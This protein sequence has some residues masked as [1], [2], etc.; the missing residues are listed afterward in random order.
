MARTPRRPAS[1]PPQTPAGASER[2]RIVEAFMALLG[3][4]P[5]EEVGFGD[6]AARAD[7][8]LADLRTL[9]GS[10][11][12]ILAFYL[13]EIDRRVLAGIDADM[14]EEPPRERLFDVLMRRLDALSAHKAAVRSL[15]RSAGRNPGLAVALN[16]FAVR[17]QQWMLTA[18]DI[19]ASGPR[20]M[21]RAQGLALLFASV[22]RTWLRDE[23]PGLARTM[24]ALDRALA[25]G[26]RF[27]GFL[28]DLCRIPA[29]IRRTRPRR[30]RDA[31]E[32][33]T[34]AA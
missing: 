2:E 31:D 30:R 10:K 9:F 11:L 1:P 21:V 6:I 25:R 23:D 28:D 29:C 27:S 12:A 33:D 4:Q 24:S 3:E 18:A 19:S 8:S 34:I 15:V 7:V 17:S 32:E 22:L 26:Q 16:G 14:A 13:K 5:I 20:G